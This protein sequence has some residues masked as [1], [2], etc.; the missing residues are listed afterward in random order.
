MR[1]ETSPDPGPS[2]PALARAGGDAAPARRAAAPGADDAP[3]P[4][5]PRPPDAYTV[6]IMT[7]EVEGRDSERFGAIVR[8]AVARLDDALAHEARLTTRV[9]AFPGP[10]L[11][12]DAGA[13]APLEFLE[14]GVAEKMERDLPFLV[15]VTEVDL[16]SSSLAYTL[17]LPS[18]LTNV[19]VV[20]TRRLDPGFWGEEPDAER[21]A[22]RLAALMRHGFGHLL[23]LG[24]EADPA[25]AMHPLG[26]VEA[27]DRMGDFSPAQRERIARALPREAN[28]RS[29][30]EGKPRFVAET[31]VRDA[32]AIGRAV[33]RAN[34]F[35]LLSRMPTMLAAALSVIVVLLFSAETW[36][37]AYAVSVP[38]IALFSLICLAAA[39]FVLHRA[40]AFEA[41]TSRDRRLTESGVVTAAATTLSLV[42]TLVVMFA[43]FG[44]LMY[45]AIVT[46]FPERLMESWPGDGEATTTLD[47][48]KLSLFLAA[49]GVLAGSLGG[50]SDSRDLVRGVLFATEDG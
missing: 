40:F 10:H 17:A 49:M 8:R 2:A 42:L 35:R 14:I 15:V 28:E 18:R 50:R 3:R 16:S 6:G 29:T 1:S 11:T 22:D 46:V 47:H 25:D 39:A 33:A 45:L 27:L 21:A 7:M 19:V 13:Y 31:L 20:S 32:G 48:V 41:L 4:A 24:H 34:P 12:P 38:Q 26:A 5:A 9:V 37:V 23:G 30:R 44:L 36:D 43:F